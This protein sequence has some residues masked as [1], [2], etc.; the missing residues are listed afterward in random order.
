MKALTR[1]VMAVQEQALS[2]EVESTA[3]KG[4]PP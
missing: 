4:F 3:F 1:V 2:E